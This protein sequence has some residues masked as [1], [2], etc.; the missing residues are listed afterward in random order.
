M[1]GKLLTLAEADDTASVDRDS[2]LRSEY[3]SRA[4]LWRV[5]GVV[6]VGENVAHLL[7]YARLTLFLAAA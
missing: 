1:R 5:C 4:N 2:A 3:T 6:V 7:A